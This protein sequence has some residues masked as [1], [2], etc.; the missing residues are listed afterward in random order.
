MKSVRSSKWG[1]FVLIFL[2]VAGPGPPASGDG[3]GGEPGGLDG[4]DLGDLELPPLESFLGTAW[5]IPGLGDSAL[6]GC[7]SLATSL[8]L[9]ND[10]LPSTPLTEEQL[11]QQTQNANDEQVK[12][13][14]TSISSAQEYYKNFFS[15]NWFDYASSTKW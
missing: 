10:V 2:K 15:I 9:D 5:G 12:I 3:G 8:E 14:F 4:L 1:E 6:V 11:L 7:G 13:T